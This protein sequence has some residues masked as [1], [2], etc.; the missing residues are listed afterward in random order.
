MAV[1]PKL[2]GFIPN[3]TKRTQRTKENLREL[4]EIG[5]G[6][7]VEEAITITLPSGYGQRHR[8][9]F[10]FARYIKTMPQYTDADPTQLRSIVTKWHKRA[11]P[12]IKTK[13]FEETWIDFVLG[14]EKVRDL[15]GDEPMTQIF[16]RAKQSPPP[17][18]AVEKYPNN[19]KLQ[20]F[21]AL[22]RELQ[23]EAGNDSFYLYC[24]TG[25]KYLEVSA[26]SISRWFMLLG[27]DKIVQEIEKGGIFWKEVDGKKKRIKKPS[28]YKYIAN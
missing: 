11:L 2:A 21:T 27:I 12:N 20:L 16:E 6:G 18:I 3:V 23:K 8:Q 28:R 19:P 10:Q 15:I 24:K 26:M 5:R 13:E 4:K 22:C 7:S 17:K 25:G 1:D 14:W 9:I